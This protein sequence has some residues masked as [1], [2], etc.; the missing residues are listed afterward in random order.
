MVNMNKENVILGQKYECHPVGLKRR[1][2]GEV[3]S[4]MEN[5]VI[6]CVED[7][8][9]IDY[10]EIQEKAG[11][12]IAKYSEIYGMKVAECFFS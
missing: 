11:K 7:F 3:I 6:L 8:D 4:K 9:G 5:C 12:V 1:V 2:V 10:D